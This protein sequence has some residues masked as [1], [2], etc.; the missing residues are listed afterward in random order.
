VYLLLVTW[1]T[2]EHPPASYQAQFTSEAACEAARA[3]LVAEGER[4][5]LEQLRN[6][7]SLG[8]R[9][10]QRGVPPKVIAICAAQ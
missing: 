3:K 1:L 10:L 8:S 5:R 2:F 7:D 4:L 6:E 9:L